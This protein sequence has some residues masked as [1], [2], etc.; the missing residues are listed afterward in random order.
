MRTPSRLSDAT[1]TIGPIIHGI[2][3]CRRSN[4]NP[5]GIPRARAR[6][7]PGKLSRKLVNSLMGHSSGAPLQGN[8]GIGPEDDLRA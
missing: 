2:G 5:A 4:R 3:A 1:A 7:M 8:C 6:S